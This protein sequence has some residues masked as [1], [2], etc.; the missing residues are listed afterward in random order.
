MKWEVN[1]KILAKKEES[2]HL[3]QRGQIREDRMSRWGSK[4]AVIQDSCDM[5][6]SN[7]THTPIG[8]NHRIRHQVGKQSRMKVLSFP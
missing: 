8:A 5:K 1:R 2:E 4:V 3:T 7:H 6:I